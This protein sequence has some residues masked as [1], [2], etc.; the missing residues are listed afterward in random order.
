MLGSTLPLDLLSTP[1]VGTHL[2]PGTF[3]D[4]LGERPTLLVFLRHLGCIFCRECMAELREARA[5]DPRFPEI[6]YFHLASIEQGDAFFAE[7]EPE[8]RAVADP[9][10][11]FY[12]AFGLTKGKLGQVFGPAVLACG[13]KAVRKGHGGGRPIGNPWMMPGFFLVKDAQ[14]AWS[15]RP[16]HIAEHPDYSNILKESVALEP[17]HSV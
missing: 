4:Q 8:A 11:H 10:H 5:A 16:K 13:I 2:R 3:Q 17:A 7:I 12:K 6:L 14:V 15:F 1:V 9:S